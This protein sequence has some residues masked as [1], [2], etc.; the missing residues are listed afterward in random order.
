MKRQLLR[1]M[2]SMFSIVSLA[3]CP[4][5]EGSASDATLG[6]GTPDS[7][8]QVPLTATGI[9]GAICA[10]QAECCPGNETLDKCQARTMAWENFLTVSNFSVDQVALRACLDRLA[11]ADCSEVAVWAGVPPLVDWCEPWFSGV[12]ANGQ[13]CGTTATGG[14]S[15]VRNAF[16]DRECVSGYCE[17]HVCHAPRKENEAC[18]FGTTACEP[19]LQCHIR[20]CIPEQG[21]GDSCYE[22]D[23][24]GN[25]TV[26]GQ[27]DLCVV[28]TVVEVGEA[29]VGDSECE[30]GPGMC[31]C[32]DASGCSDKP[33]VCGNTARCLP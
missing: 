29:C 12:A 3:A 18:Q 28:P 8:S 6:D 11:T 5:D 19:G 14:A 2:F 16:S 10:R 27:E 4:T 22:R 26:C 1:A 21:A 33:T 23:V 7:T 17:S 20:V 9:Q 32:A 15:I 31:R 30:L 24:C 13:A 25:G